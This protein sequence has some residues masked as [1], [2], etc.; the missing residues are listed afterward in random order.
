MNVITT[1]IKRNSNIH[2]IKKK[3][4]NHPPAPHEA[5]E[6]SKKI[7]SH[8]KFMVFLIINSGFK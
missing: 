2:I 5:A 3:P 4:D 7:I 8:Q 1:N 6:F